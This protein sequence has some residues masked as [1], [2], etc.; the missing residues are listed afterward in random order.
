MSA[1]RERSELLALL[2]KRWNDEV[3]DLPDIYRRPAFKPAEL[4]QNERAAN[5]WGGANPSDPFAAARCRLHLSH[6]YVNAV[7][8]QKD[9]AALVK[10]NTYREQEEAS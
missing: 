2:Q 1:V 6:G 4:G 7:D 3:K 8:V 5:A 10:R 9:A